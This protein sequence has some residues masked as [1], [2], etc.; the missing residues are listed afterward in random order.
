MKLWNPVAFF[1]SL[2]MS[3]FMP[4]IF[5]IP[6][7]MP[8]EVCLIQWPIRWFIA[9]LLIII[10]VSDLSVKLAKR[11]FGFNPKN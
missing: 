9:Y 2:M 3:L 10:F 6:S 11:V 1:I 5:A 4:L 8:F 7:G